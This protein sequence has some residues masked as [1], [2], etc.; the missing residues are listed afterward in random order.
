MVFT[1]PSLASAVKLGLFSCL[2]LWPMFGY[3]SQYAAQ[4]RLA[5]LIQIGHELNLQAKIDYQLS[6]TAKEALHKGVPLTWEVQ[7]EIYETGRLWNSTV[8][9]QRLPY[10]LQFHALLNQ[11][12][13]LIANQQ[14]EMFLTLNAALSFMSAPQL[15]KPIQAKLLK[16]G[17]AYTLALKSIFDRELLPVPLRPF[18]YLDAQWFLSSSWYLWPILK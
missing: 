17:H 15:T 4:I 11:Y 2:L 3:A 18:S 7:V 13:V 16:K 10:Q 12:E 8:F 6:P 5:E 9:S 1:M 14:S